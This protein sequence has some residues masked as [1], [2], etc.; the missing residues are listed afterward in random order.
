M[1][2]IDKI[3]NSD[4]SRSLPNRQ[5]PEVLI[6][7]DDN[8]HGQRLIRIIEEKGYRTRWARSIKEAEEALDTNVRY[9]GAIVDVFIHDDNSVHLTK[10]L[11]SEQRWTYIIGLT[12]QQ[13][14]AIEPIVSQMTLLCDEFHRRPLAY[15][16]LTESMARGFRERMERI[17][18]WYQGDCSEIEEKQNEAQES[19]VLSGSDI[20]SDPDILAYQRMRDELLRLYPN[21]YVAFLNE[22]FVGHH[23]EYKAL[24]ENVINEFGRTDMFITKVTEVQERVTI[25]RPLKVVDLE[26][27]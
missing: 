20:D 3:K 14:Q 21:Q 12:G 6:I 17:A 9:E 16:K 13:G 23:E 2:E 24:V 25:P 11:S 8:V 4:N 26:S 1:I 5:V 10:R 7:E 22:E 18:D 27:N 15:E 19:P